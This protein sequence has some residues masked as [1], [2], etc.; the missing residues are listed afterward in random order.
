MEDNF[1]ELFRLVDQFNGLALWLQAAICAGTAI[2]LCLI[3]IGLINLMSS[4]QPP[5]AKPGSASIDGAPEEIRSPSP[6]AVALQRKKTVRSEIPSSIEKL[7]EFEI[8]EEAAPPSPDDDADE[9][10]PVAAGVPVGTP[11]RPETKKEI[12]KERTSAIA[13]LGQLVENIPRIMRVGIPIEVEARIAQNLEDNIKLDMPGEVMTHE[14]MTTPAMT[15]MLR[16][17]DGGFQIEPIT[18]ET[19][20]VSN[21]QAQDLGLIDQPNFG[22]WLWRVTPSSRGRRRLKFSVAAHPIDQQV[23]S[24]NIPIPQQDIEIKVRVNY[25]SAVQK[26]LLWT[27]LAVAGGIAAKFGEDLWSKAVE[28][29]EKLL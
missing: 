9:L 15:V 16:A 8:A 1:A 12:K 20:W 14:I 22:Q 21:K 23:P 11:P 2:L 7:E 10:A 3:I 29:A 5:E 25:R 6:D 28:A 17:P 19:Q 24:A 27:A 13:K 18:L 4:N 26:V